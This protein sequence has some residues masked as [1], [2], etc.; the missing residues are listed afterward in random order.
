M[1]SN[2]TAHRTQN[3]KEKGE[4]SVRIVAPTALNTPQLHEALRD[5]WEDRKELWNDQYNNGLD[6]CDPARG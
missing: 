2:K 1:P 4:P 3:G 6:R 5:W